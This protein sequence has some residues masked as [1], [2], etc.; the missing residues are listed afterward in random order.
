MLTAVVIYYAA[1][2]LYKG[3]YAPLVAGLYFVAMAPAMVYGRM[4]FY[5]NLV[6]PF[7]AATI[8]CVAKFENGGGR[9]W[10]YVGALLAALAPFGK[11]DGLFVPLFFTIWALS[12]GKARRTVVPVILSWGPIAAAGAV[13][14]SLV[15]NFQGVLY[16]WYFGLVGRE[17]S[18]QFLFIQSLLSGYVAFDQ[19]Y[20]K[21]D[22]WYLFGFLC[23]GVLIILGSRAGRILMEVVFAFVA[24][25][26]LSFG[27]GT[28]YPIMLFPVFALAA[29]GGVGYLSKMGNIG[30]LGMYT[31]F[32]A[33]LVVS[34]IGSTTLPFSGIDYPLFF[35]KGVLFVLP[36]LV[37][38]LLEGVSIFRLK[39]H[40]PLSAV[41]LICFF[42]LLLAGTPELYSYYFLGRLM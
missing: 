7:L 12:S 26:F 29:A 38:R 33:P 41:V 39:K 40:F 9:R 32:Y 18:M 15:G 21:P 22:F 31:F 19:G 13:I 2:Q 34:F 30:A 36:G 35:L 28:Y 42:V 6:R 1:R 14:L 25:F 16:Q 24:V 11:V 20:I 23:L 4:I 37:W 3:K 10:L 17:L 8:Y 5:E 27:V